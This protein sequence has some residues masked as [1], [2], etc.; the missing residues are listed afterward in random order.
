MLEVTVQSDLKSIPKPDLG[1]CPTG[2]HGPNHRQCGFVG[3]VDL[4]TWAKAHRYRFRLEGSYQAENN[5][6]VRG[7]GRWFVEVLCRNGLIYPHGGRILLAYVK[8]GVANAIA[9]LGPDIEP[10]QNDGSA[11][12]FKFPVAR[13]D[14]VA[15]ILKPRKRRAVGASPEQLRAM[16]ERRKSL[17]QVKQIDQ[18]ATQSR[19]TTIGADRNRESAFCGSQAGQIAQDGPHRTLSGERNNKLTQTRDGNPQTERP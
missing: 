6:H 11:R 10:Y 12:V 7:D 3:C 8:A 2:D 15:A 16:R 14:E 19:E 1:T 17:G 5:T 9:A 18:E 4:R 13:L